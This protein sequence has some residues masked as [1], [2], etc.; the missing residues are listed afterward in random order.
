MHIDKDIT[1]LV[2]INHQDLCVIIGSTEIHN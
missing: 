1:C 2:T